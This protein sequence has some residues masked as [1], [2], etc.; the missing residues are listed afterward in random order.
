MKFI[1]GGGTEVT[2]GTISSG[3]VKIPVPDARPSVT[4]GIS[5]KETYAT[6]IE[7]Q[8]SDEG[9]S[10]LILRST[11]KGL[12][13]ETTIKSSMSNK[14]APIYMEYTNTV[15][16]ASNPN[17]INSIPYLGDTLMGY[18]SSRFPSGMYDE[19]KKPKNTRLRVTVEIEQ[20]CDSTNWGFIRYYGIDVKVGGVSLTRNLHSL[21]PD[22]SSY[23][24]TLTSS[25]LGGVKL[26]T[27]VSVKLNYGSTMDMFWFM[28]EHCR[29]KIKVTGVRVEGGIT[30]TQNATLPAQFNNA[31]FS[32]AYWSGSF[33]ELSDSYTNTIKNNTSRSIDFKLYRDGTSTGTAR[34]TARTISAGGTV[35]ITSSDWSELTV[36]GM[37]NAQYKMYI[38]NLE[39][40]AKLEAKMDADYTATS[41]GGGHIYLRDD[42]NYLRGNTELRG[43]DKARLS[44]RSSE[45]GNTWGATGIDFHNS[46]LY[47]SPVL[48]ES[49]MN[50]IRS[51]LP[52]NL[53][54][55]NIKVSG[56]TTGTWYKNNTAHPMIIM[57]TNNSTFGSITLQNESGTEISGGKTV[58][59]A[60]QGQ[61]SGWNSYTVICPPRWSFK[62][63]GDGTKRYFTC[64]LRI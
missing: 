33:L 9:D 20:P 2:M 42:G 12:T 56:Y 22:K 29:P 38:S 41:S 16:L 28:F 45:G 44:I 18:S 7:G 54:V 21:T 23:E 62:F 30:T 36:T 14:G 1:K 34:G 53:H 46:N 49:F 57:F 11:S 32:Y 3:Q 48:S 24:Y 64:L 17:G 37:Y 35:N 51:N 13:D 61:G 10:T 47:G 26:G 8:S 50:S 25:N 39:N 59:G 60:V 58:E 63:G 43:G 5:E 40:P 15:T 27:T 52:T 55:S 4:G 6:I 19:P 31:N